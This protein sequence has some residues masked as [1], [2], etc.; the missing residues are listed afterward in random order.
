MLLFWPCFLLFLP[1]EL[2]EWG[3]VLAAEVDIDV[4]AVDGTEVDVVDDGFVTIS[5]TMRGATVVVVVVPA[6]ALV[7]P[8]AAPMRLLLLML[9]SSSLELIF[10]SI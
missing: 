9:E 10:F 3:F 6:V 4:V 1:L 7:T 5:V 8:A 2:L